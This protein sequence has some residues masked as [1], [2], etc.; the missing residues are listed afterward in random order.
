MSP[1]MDQQMERQAKIRIRVS[2]WRVHRYHLLI[3]KHAQKVLMLLCTAGRTGRSPLLLAQMSIADSTLQER[4]YYM[5]TARV[6]DEAS[7][8]LLGDGMQSYVHPVIV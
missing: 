3:H 7:S 2:M 4:R 8:N 6:Q 5:A 1:Q